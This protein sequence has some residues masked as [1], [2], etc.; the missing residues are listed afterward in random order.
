[1]RNF[2]KKNRSKVILILA[3][4]IMAVVMCIYSISKLQIATN[5]VKGEIKA[6]LDTPPDGYTAIT[7]VQG[8]KDMANDLSGKYMLMADINLN[9][10]EWTPI[11]LNSGTSFKGIFDGNF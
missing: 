7:D 8:L 10:E 3:F 5:R 2:I 9:G 6:Q 1:M 4:V 11:G